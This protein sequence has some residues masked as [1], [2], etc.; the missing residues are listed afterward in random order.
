MEDPKSVCATNDSAICNSDEEIHSSFNVFDPE[1]N[2]ERTN[3][4]SSSS[5]AQEQDEGEHK[6]AN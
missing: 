5:W 2:E 6:M 3:T 4:E 1:S